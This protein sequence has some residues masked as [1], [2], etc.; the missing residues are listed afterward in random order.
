VRTIAHLDMD[1]FYVSVEL[2][3]HP[4]LRGRPVIVAGSSP[5]AVVT[6]ASYEARR[7]GISSA[8]PAARAHRLCPDAVRLTP[9]FDAY[10]TVSGRIM[11]ILRR[12]VEL[13]EVAGLDEAYLDLTGM[14]APRAGM[15]RVAGEI[16]AATG[17]D[18]S[19]GIGPSKLIAKLASDC[20]KPRGRVALTRAQALERFGGASA[21]LLPGVGPKTL[22]RLEAMRIRTVAELGAADP[23]QLASRFGPTLGRF[24]HRRARLDDDSPVCS[25]RPL[26]SSSNE[27]TFPADVSDPGVLE[28][29]IR[30]LSAELARTLDRRRLS[31]RTIG[32]KVRLDDFTTVTRA[33][34][35]GCAD[36]DAERIAGAALELLRTYGPPRPVRLLGVRASSL[37]G[38]PAASA[39][40]DQEPQLA[41]ELDS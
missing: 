37:V 36:C 18:C 35:D 14:L 5:R 10:R 38:E 32:I 9:D 13:V 4:E 22:A 16:H 12:N 23:E 26:V 3:R 27:T 2:Q 34:T 7:F 28:A 33:R 39:G 11:E 17:L 31:A 8:M 15:A 41:L 21:R 19:I 29:T 40:A 24:L 20:E 30:R 6:T 25:A 1:A